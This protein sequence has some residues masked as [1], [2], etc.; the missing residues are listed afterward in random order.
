M[1]SDS[2]RRSGTS[3]LPLS[4]RLPNAPPVF[5]GRAREVAFLADTIPSG[6]VT[7]VSGEGGLGKSALTL[8]VLHDRFR[9]RV[10]STV[11]VSLRG[12]DPL[13][14]PALAAA[15]ALMRAQGTERVDWSEML[16]AP[17]AL[18]TFA[19]D[20]ADAQ[21]RWVVL[22]DLHHARSADVESFLLQLVRYARSSRWI[23]TMRDAP[24][25]EDL[26]RSGI[27]L[28]AMGREELLELAAA[29]SPSSPREALDRA[30]LDADG[31]PWRLRQVHAKTPRDHALAPGD[32]DKVLSRETVEFLRVLALVSPP[33][34]EAVLDAI[35]P[36]PAEPLADLERRALIERTAEG[37]R[38][39]ELT[40][41]IL[42]PLDAATDPSCLAAKAGRA[43]GCARE[44]ALRL[45]GIR[46]MLS[47]GV[48]PSG[49]LDEGGDELLAAG[50]APGLWSVLE[51]APRRLVT[52]RVDRWRLYAAIQL[53][54]SHVLARVRAPDDP[55]TE[56]ELSWATLLSMKGELAAADARA[57]SAARRATRDG[58]THTACD[59]GILR[60]RC[61]GNLGKQ[62]EALGI[63]ES[64]VP[65]D[66]LRAARV[67][68]LRTLLLVH[69]GRPDDALASADRLAAAL[70]ELQW[71]AR[72]EIGQRVVLA[73]Y[74]L[75]RLREAATAFDETVAADQPGSVRFDVGRMLRQAR[76]C[77][78]VD[79]G[80]LERAQ[81]EFDAVEPYLGYGSLLRDFVVVARAVMALTAGD[82]DACD[83]RCAD[84]EGRA[85]PSQIAHDVAATRLQALVLAR[86]EPL[87]PRAIP[88]GDHVGRTA[89]RLAR[90]ELALRA[91]RL[92][93]RDAIAAVADP[94]WEP[95]MRIR[96]RII[97][98]EA[99]LIEGDAEAAI[100]DA[101]AA[102]A[103][104]DEHGYVVREAEARQLLCDAFVVAG[105]DAS[106]RAE[107]DALAAFVAPIG[108]P[109]FD[110]AARLHVA[111]A[112][113]A[114]PDPATLEALAAAEPALCAGTRARRLFG[115]PCGDALDRLVID[116]FAARA[117][118][119]APVLVSASAP[120]SRWQPG[121]GIDAVATRV[122][123]ADGRSVDLARHPVSWAL[124]ACLAA[125][126]G[127]A[128]KE[129]IVVDVWKERA[130]HP[131]RH[132]NRLQAAVRKLR[133][134]IEDDPAHPARFVTTA[135]GYALAG[136]VRHRVRAPS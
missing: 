64:L 67:E 87:E 60:A 43:L 103:M 107:A 94:G 84:L 57:A 2:T 78:A 49:A 63:V 77:V 20:L 88:D 115:G 86:A 55:S 80:D 32:V 29:L 34:P 75:G 6:P 1:A 26:E 10:D 105:R 110:R 100:A 35:A 30:V 121:W 58:D 5:T 4:C 7:I 65:P 19:L 119:V 102:I 120:S 79:G 46:L 59:A 109:R 23:V 17:D 118:H 108:S 111:L 83:R 38:L 74:Y 42:P 128:S 11:F 130:Y 93:P 70:P 134:Q 131:L 126:R 113:P 52:E 21:D 62:Q 82:L 133:V 104:A 13:E 85:I 90:V 18:A 22:D 54:D 3:P 97:A 37:L 114:G 31:S 92:A 8:F 33:I 51:S 123:S 44:P 45:E 48:D 95:E 9:E 36:R 96:A 61:L 12:G 106:H 16:G 25:G 81:R 50:Y 71:P 116:A 101:T 39:H 40:R 89:P 66:A 72:A 73:Y 98:A 91:G 24:R 135:D 69:V 27:R 53:G 41:A 56:V 124:L 136:I 99:R 76:G 129:E 125:R 68:G 117:S 122:W 28:G 132:D 112:N 14:P 127:A 15:R 47:A